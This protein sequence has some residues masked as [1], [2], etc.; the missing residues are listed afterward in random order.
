MEATSAPWNTNKHKEEKRFDRLGGVGRRRR[1]QRVQ[2]LD[3]HAASESSGQRLASTAVSLG[4]RCF[5]AE[6]LSGEA[7]REG[8]KDR[9][10]SASE[11]VV[12]GSTTG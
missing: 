7:E 3:T 5:L 12:S 10:W 4:A 1:I 9:E 11:E 8:D 6:R 2:E